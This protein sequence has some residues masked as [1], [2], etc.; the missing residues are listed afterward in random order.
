M[1]QPPSPSIRISEPDAG[2]QIYEIEHPV[3]AAR[4]ARHGAQVMEWRPAG[5][6]APVLYLSPAAVFREGRPIRGGI[7]LC[8]PWFNAHPDDPSQPSHGIARTAFWEPVEV[9]DDE[10]GVTLRFSLEHPPF[11]AAVRIQ[12]GKFLSV[13]LETTNR[14]DA[15]RRVSGALHS[16]LHVGDLSQIR[17]EGLR[18]MSYLDT[19]GGPVR[20]H[21]D[22]ELAI[23]GETDRIYDSSGSCSLLDP[24][25]GRRIIVGKEG[26]PSTVVWN[27]WSGK[28]AALADLPDEGYR[29]FVCIEAAA[30]NDRAVTLA[31]GESHILATTIRVEEL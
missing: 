2:Y 3:C 5:A 30:A 14:G 21:Q 22:S 1:T 15:P 17:I 19:V 10:S 12:L 31:P 29:D 7:P 23:D 18:E 6:G 16:Y 28:A 8:W 25:L 11:H 20:R 4:V 13:A 26:S 24:A 9:T 27:P